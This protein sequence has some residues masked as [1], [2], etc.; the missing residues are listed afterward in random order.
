MKVYF[1]M[2]ERRYYQRLRK[3]S[4]IR[5]KKLINLRLGGTQY[6]SFPFSVFDFRTIEKVIAGKIRMLKIVN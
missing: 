1:T 5:N 2:E 4:V 3:D 6:K